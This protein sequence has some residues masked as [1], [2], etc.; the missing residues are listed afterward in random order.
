[1][2]LFIIGTKSHRPPAAGNC[3]S[4]LLEDPLDQMDQKRYSNLLCKV[5]ERQLPAI[6]LIVADI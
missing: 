4:T 3:S 6:L 5:Q 1:M 2:G